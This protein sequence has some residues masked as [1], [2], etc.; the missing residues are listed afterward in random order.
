MKKYICLLFILFVPHVT[1][2]KEN[3][4]E[5]DKILKQI[6]LKIPANW[7]IVVDKDRI[8]F[9]RN[10]QV[11]SLYENM[12]NAP[13]SMETEDERA[14]RIKKFGTKKKTQIVYEFEPK[15]NAK[16]LQNVKVQ[17]HLIYNKINGL[18][19]K[20][21]IEHLYND[22]LSSKGKDFFNKGTDEENIRV[23]KY[24]KEK[25]KLHA[26]II[27]LPDFNTE[28]YSL[29]FIDGSGYN[30]INELVYPYEASEEAYRI[31]NLIKDVTTPID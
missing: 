30:D 31:L 1:M 23:E 21:K 15:W 18:I 12:I 2:A 5:K 8:I 27:K 16:R 19:K 14:M 26:K 10:D 9:E 28:K 22:M 3:P 29:F 6:S 20:Y 24:K 11:Y 13:I 17:D 4:M 25:Q 7:K